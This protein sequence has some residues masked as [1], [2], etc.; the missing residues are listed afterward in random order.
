MIAQQNTAST[1]SSAPPSGSSSPS[2]SSKSFSPSP[3]ACAISKTCTTQPPYWN[4]PSH[5]SSPSGCSRS[6][7]TFYLLCILSTRARDLVLVVARRRC[8]W[9]RMTSLAVRRVDVQGI[10]I[11]V[12]YRK[13][14]IL[15][16]VRGHWEGMM[17]GLLTA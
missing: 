11:M 7:S 4:G 1:A 16:R 3:S 6:S 9:S 14:E 8:K 15:L 5:S 10:I 12:G 13:A 17:F 2:S